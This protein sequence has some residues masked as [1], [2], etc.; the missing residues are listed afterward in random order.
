MTKITFTEWKKQ[1][2]KKLRKTY[3]AQMIISVI[4]IALDGFFDIWRQLY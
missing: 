2:D 4:F 1:I 3:Q